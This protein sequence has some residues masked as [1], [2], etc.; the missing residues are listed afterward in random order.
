MRIQGQSNVVPKITINTVSEDNFHEVDAALQR[1]K[2][3]PSGE[4]LLKSISKHSR[5]GKS[6]I[7]HIVAFESTQ[8]IP[9]L[10]NKQAIRFKDVEDKENVAR[11]LAVKRGYCKA[12]G[13]S[14]T[15]KYN[16]FWEE[17]GMSNGFSYED[18]IQDDADANDT[19]LFHE[20]VHA[21]RIIKG[22]YTDDNSLYGHEDEM[23]RAIGSMQY[24]DHPVTENK[25]REQT[26]HQLRAFYPVHINVDN[27]NMTF[28]PGIMP[29]H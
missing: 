18:I 26:G 23:L 1:I 19:T 20:L 12:K 10:T 4:S 3:T 27:T 16:Q 6:V 7:I 5:N 29:P 2:N 13:T 17:V 21:M 15:I 8:T 9:T 14:A 24:A 11:N 28:R 22:T 25:F